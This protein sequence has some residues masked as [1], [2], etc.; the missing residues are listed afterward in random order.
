MEPLLTIER[1]A[2]L[3]GISHWTVRYYVRIKKLQPVRIGR[4]ILFE[5]SELRRLIDAGRSPIPVRPEPIST[6]INSIVNAR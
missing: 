2:A 5:E 6:E 3:L 4:K 1:A